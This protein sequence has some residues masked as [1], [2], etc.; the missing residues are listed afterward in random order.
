MFKFIKN[1]AATI[2]NVDIY[3]IFSLLLFFI[4]FVAV[5]YFVQKMNKK[6]V[7]ELS[8][9]PLNDSLEHEPSFTSTNN[10]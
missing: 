4:F 1:Y 9:L 3:P 5:L 8:N 10:S 6:Q 7:S 2:K